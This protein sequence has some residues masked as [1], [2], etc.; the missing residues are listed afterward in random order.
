[1]LRRFAAQHAIDFPIET[2]NNTL[3]RLNQRIEDRNY[4]LGHS[5]FLRPNLPVEIESIW[6]LEIEPYLEEYFFDQPD[7]VDNWRWERVKKDFGL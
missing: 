7:E 4:E 1:M 5:F 6:R 2:L 3:Q